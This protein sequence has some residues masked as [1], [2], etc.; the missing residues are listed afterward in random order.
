MK[1]MQHHRCLEASQ[2]KSLTKCLHLLIFPHPSH[3]SHG[4]SSLQPQTLEE[5]HCTFGVFHAPLRSEPHG[6]RYVSTAGVRRR[7]SS[8]GQL[9]AILPTVK[10]TGRMWAT[11]SNEAETA[12]G[13]SELC[14]TEGPNNPEDLI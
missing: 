1:N 10:T 7:S 2:I 3:S 14:A 5:S 9:P 6:T 12:A 13:E 4:H 8:H 11:R